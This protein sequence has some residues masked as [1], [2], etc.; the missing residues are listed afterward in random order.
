MVQEGLRCLFAAFLKHSQT[1]VAACF[2]GDTA[3]GTRAAAPDKAMVQKFKRVD[4]LRPWLI[5]LRDQAVGSDATP[6]PAAAS[7]SSSSSSSASASASAS[8]SAS[9]GTAPA[10]SAAATGITLPEV[11]A[12]CRFML[13]FVPLA[14]S[15]ENKQVLKCILASSS[16]K[17]KG[18][19]ANSWKQMFHGWRAMRKLRGLLQ[20]SLAKTLTKTDTTLDLLLRFCKDPRVSLPSF[21]ARLLQRRERGRIRCLGLEYLRK[22]L[23]AG[24]PRK[25]VLAPAMA[26]PRTPDVWPREVMWLSCRGGRIAPGGGGVVWETGSRVTGLLLYLKDFGAEGA[27]RNITSKRVFGSTQGAST[28]CPTE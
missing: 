13:Q 20:L 28:M 2:T 23:S 15:P 27:G 25:E 5:E 11:I 26:L 14:C 10:A 22:Q 8:P 9:T 18:T 19:T 3:K 1:P 4:A 17:R 12:R 24:V 6:G 16:A 7:S 21:H